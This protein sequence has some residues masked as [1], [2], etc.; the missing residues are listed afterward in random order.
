[1]N[2]SR[3]PGEDE[4][5]DERRREALADYDAELTAAVKQFAADQL[6]RRRTLVP[7]RREASPPHDSVLI[8]AFEHAGDGGINVS[9]P[10]ANMGYQ[11]KAFC[12]CEDPCAR[13]HQIWQQHDN[14]MLSLVTASTHC[15]VV[16]APPGETF[17]YHT[18]RL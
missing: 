6:P 17:Q 3:N 8:T 11:V 14:D 12:C 9:D 13:D 16:I 10:A 4:P 2:L 5:H 7:A 18:M 15:S 1:M